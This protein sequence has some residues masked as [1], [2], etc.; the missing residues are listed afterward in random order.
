MPSV[1]QAAPSSASSTRARAASTFARTRRLYGR[2]K[3]AIVG[4]KR[5]RRGV[6]IVSVAAKCGAR[7]SE[8]LYTSLYVVHGS[9]NWLGSLSVNSFGAGG[10]SRFAFLVGPGGSGLS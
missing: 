2:P 9:V 8:V 6:A 10:G 3:F 7:S 5:L 4:Q 1:V